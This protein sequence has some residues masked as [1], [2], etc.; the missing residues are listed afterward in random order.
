MKASIAWLKSLTPTT[1]DA[2]GLVSSLTMAGLEVDAVVSIAH[3]FTDV[4]VAEVRRVEAH[5]EADKLHVCQV[6][7]GV[8]EWQ[9][10]CGAPN[11]RVG[12]KAPL[13]RVGAQLT[14]SVH[15][16]TAM[17]RG[18]ESHGMLCGADELGLAEERA[19]L[20]ELPGD[21]PVGS[22]LQAYLSLP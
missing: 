22:T 9:V 2:Q 16:H 11:V 10:V 3:P 15:I 5:P 6:F 4:V 20:M 19:G 13:A 18:V 17:L 8:R 1:L 7:D 21:A 12:L 14:E